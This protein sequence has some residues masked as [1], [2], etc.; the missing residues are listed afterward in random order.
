GIG[1]GLAGAA[2]V[3]KASRI[4]EIR[5]SVDWGQ[6]AG[7]VAIVLVAAAL[8]SVLPARRAVRAAPIEALSD[9]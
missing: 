7:F 2:T 4:T 3:A 9:E 8:A 6:I 1:F 5:L